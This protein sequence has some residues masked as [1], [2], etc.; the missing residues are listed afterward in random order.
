MTAS[1]SPLTNSTTSGRRTV[2]PLGDGE[3]IDRE[4]VVVVRIVEIDHARLRAGDRAV[5]AAVFD[6]DAVHQHAMQSAI[7]LD[8]RRR[9]ELDQLAIGVFHRFRRQIGIQPGQRRLQAILQD[10]VTIVRI[11]AL[12]GRLTC[13]D[14][15]AVQHRIAERLQPAE[16]GFFDD[17]FGER[18]G[19]HHT[20]ASVPRFSSTV[21]LQIAIGQPKFAHGSVT[22]SRGPARFRLCR[23]LAMMRI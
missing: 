23:G 19:G 2:L 1:G 8:Q 3:L 18:A 13:R 6:R 17:R 15:R 22:A 20:P 7:T 4:P 12:G 16:R 5:L 11:F 9:I 14:R 10:N 21:Q